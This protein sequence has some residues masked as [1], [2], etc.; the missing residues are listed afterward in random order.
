MTFAHQRSHA[1]LPLSPG[2]AAEVAGRS[3][4]PESPSETRLLERRE[5]GWQQDLVLLRQKPIGPAR[6]RPVRV[7]RRFAPDPRALGEV[8]VPPDV[9]D[10]VEGPDLR[11][12]EG[13]QRGVLLPVLVGL[14]VALLDL[15]QAA[16]GDPVGSDL[17]DHG[18]LLSRGA[19]ITRPS[20]R[21]R[22]LAPRAV[23][24]PR[25]CGGSA[26][27]LDIVRG[28]AYLSPHS[29]WG[30]FRLDL[31]TLEPWGA[32]RDLARDRPSTDHALVPRSA[33]ASLR[34]IEDRHVE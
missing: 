21:A 25:T 32:V 34:T 23:R 31:Y 17:V 19:P 4:Q 2:L 10:L 20:H 29:S 18:R 5:R 11:V 9:D 22:S 6:R 28:P 7:L 30:R 8:P 12:P 1:W 16:G 33:L 24:L 14:A 3:R 26:E 15:G 27:A 13:G